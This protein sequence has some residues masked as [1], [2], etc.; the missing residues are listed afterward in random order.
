MDTAC[1]RRTAGPQNYIQRA[2][3]HPCESVEIRVRGS[4]ASFPLS[5]SQVVS[6]LAWKQQISLQNSQ[7]SFPIES[8]D[9]GG[10]VDSE[11]TRFSSG[12]G[13]TRHPTHLNFFHNNWEWRILK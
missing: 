10:Q 5:E 1:A 11:W 6:Q 7:L 12:P 2:P 9:G 13:E 4:S 3:Q 8:L